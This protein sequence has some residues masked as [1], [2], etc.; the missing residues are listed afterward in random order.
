MAISFLCSFTLTVYLWNNILEEDG[1]AIPCYWS[2]SNE[3]DVR[4]FESNACSPSFGAK[5]SNYIQ[6][7]VHEYTSFFCICTTMLRTA[8]NFKS[9]PGFVHEHIR[10]NILSVYPNCLIAYMKIMCNWW[11]R[12]Y[13]LWKLHFM[14][15]IYYKYGI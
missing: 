1:K 14:I 11:I 6:A 10:Y 5:A 15:Y 7:R 3:S 8:T 12:R 2:T 9:T 13:C 4:D